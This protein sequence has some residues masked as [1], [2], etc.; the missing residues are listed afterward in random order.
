MFKTDGLNNGAELIGYRACE[1]CPVVVGASIA[2]PKSIFAA[3]YFVN[4][5]TKHYL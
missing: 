5:I 2:R 1:K 4:C 3:I